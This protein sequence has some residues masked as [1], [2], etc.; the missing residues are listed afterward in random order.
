[1]RRV[2]RDLLLPQPILEVGK[3]NRELIQFFGRQ[4]LDDSLHTLDPLAHN[5]IVGYVLNRP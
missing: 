3:P 1:M 5:L 2:P 4:F